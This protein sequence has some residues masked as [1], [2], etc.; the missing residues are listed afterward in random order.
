MPVFMSYDQIERMISALLD[1]AAQWHPDAVVGIMRGGLVPATMAAGILALP[2]SIITCERRSGAVSWIGPP[3][4]GARILLIDDCCASGETM[5][6]AR[7]AMLDQGHTCLTLT[8]VYDPETTAYVPDLSHPMR[9]LFRF[10]WERGESTPGARVLRATGAPSDR[11]TEAPF[12]GLVLDG[13][14]APGVPRHASERDLPTALERR[15]AP[16]PYTALPF[17]TPERAVVITGRPQGERTSIAAWLAQHGHGALPLEC[18]PVEL[19]PDALTIARYKA[20][21]ATRW[22]CTH[23]IESD[24]EQAIRIA[25][26]APH[27]IVQW[28][29]AAQAQA[30]IVAAAHGRC[31]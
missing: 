12:V 18:R 16:A 7:L 22:G 5:R 19:P 29:S 26:L 6:A 23:F 9:A 25:A 30:W 21:A 3:A 10:P 17:F 14:F 31:C 2:L 4:D 8:V 15:Q 13:V 27:V 24:P 20:E 11:R 28:W 1:R